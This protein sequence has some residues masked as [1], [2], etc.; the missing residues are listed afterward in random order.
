MEEN[1]RHKTDKDGLV[2]LGDTHGNWASLN[3]FCNNYTNFCIV[4]VGDA[5][6]GF[7]HPLKEG[8]GRNFPF[9]PLI[10]FGEIRAGKI[11]LELIVSIIFVII[12]FTPLEISIS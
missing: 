11:L 7:D 12:E 4:H 2:V 5:G 10:S 9:A 6:I 1:F 8:L 3:N